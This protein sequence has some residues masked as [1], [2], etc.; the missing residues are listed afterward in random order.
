MHA[1]IETAKS[2]GFCFGVDRAVKL[3]Y[4][5]LDEG[6][7]VATLGPIVHNASVVGDLNAKG[8]RIVSGP[9]ELSEGETLIIRAH[10]VP[11]AVY[12]QLA[13][14]GNP[15][16]DATCPFVARIHKIVAEQTAAGRHVFIAGDPQH[17]EVQ[18]IVGHCMGN[19]TVFRDASELKCL[20][21]RSLPERLAIV[22]Q[23]TYNKLL[24]G[25]CIELLPSDHPD[26]QVFDTICSATA[27]RQSDADLLSRASD[28]MIIAG[29]RHS[30]NTVKL[31][32][33]CSRN[34]PSWLIE[35]AE[36]LSEHADEI[37]HCA[38]EI[39]A[40]AGSGH[41][42]K[43]GIT[44]GAST[45]A[46]II[47]EV[48]TN[49]SGIFDT[50]TNIPENEDFAAA[51]EEELDKTFTKKI[52]KGDRVV[53]IVASISGN[54]EVMVDVGAKQTGYITLSELTSDTS[55]KPSD[56]VKVGDELELVVI[57]VNDAEGTVQLSK[58]RVD[59]MIGFENILK[60]YE[61][62]EVLEG[63]VISVVKGG[64]V[65]DSNGV[66]VFIPASQ[67]GLGRGADLNV[68]LKQQI[69]FVIIDVNEQRRRAVGSIRQV[70]KAERDAA[71]AKFWETAK[72]GDVY[73]GEV[74]SLTSY[75]AFVDLGGIDGMVHVS[76]LSWARI[77]QPSDVVEVG[78]T[79]EV[80][81]KALNPETGRISLGH[82]RP[83]DNPWVKFTNEYAVGDIVDATIV[84]VTSF[85]AFARITDGIDGLIHISQLSNERVSNVKDVVNVGDVVT[86]KIT[87]IDTEKKRISLS[88]RAVND[89]DAAADEAEEAESVAYSD[90]APAEEAP[91]EDAAE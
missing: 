38:A 62:G 37:R 21:D 30:S 75:G 76:E 2:A 4:Q 78:D 46:H 16:I 45:P 15:V 44:A 8:A 50:D 74:K 17:P 60:A 88:M 79:L 26:L 49:M 61:A 84:S 70:Q 1:E 48:Q 89:D 40:K 77:H 33:V 11:Q 47:K 59:E 66:H 71:K 91:A 19:C 65:A 53:G 23:T 10:G 68:L 42:L 67:S 22:A 81:I 54:N 13:A 9:E 55:K 28:L 39:A 57:Q 58:R 43:I 29:G 32:D 6:K 24:W 82:R 12:Q 80:Y 64:L 73:T 51:F 56:L 41:V 36:E 90:E 3:V 20:I 86:V 7:R 69:R 18:G 27:A 63:T 25:E 52:R 85:G 72:V 34:C 5:A 35:T 31:Y 14:Q 83:E 87:A